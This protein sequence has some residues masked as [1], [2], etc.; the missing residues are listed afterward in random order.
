MQQRRRLDTVLACC[1]T[2][3]LIVL[4][5]LSA[6]LLYRDLT[7]AGGDVFELQYSL[8]SLLVVCILVLSTGVFLILCNAFR[9]RLWLFGAVHRFSAYEDIPLGEHADLITGL[10][11][12]GLA[13]GF[14]A[15]H[16]PR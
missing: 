9:N 6:S 13:I 15:V 2:G 14:F 11:L 8:G 1:L 16:F 7:R 4:V 10:A 12:V 3:L 5:G